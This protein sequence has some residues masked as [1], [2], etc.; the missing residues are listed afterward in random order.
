MHARIQGYNDPCSAGLLC[1]CFQ[2]TYS[3]HWQSRPESQSLRYSASNAQPGE[4]SGTR[5]ESDAVQ[6]C[7]CQPGFIQHST[8]H[9]QN[10]FG[11]A[12]PRKN[13]LTEDVTLQQQRN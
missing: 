13:L 11:M 2:C 1:Q 12:L 9:R 4:G 10:Q 3:D 8:Y 5:A 6:L 7:Q